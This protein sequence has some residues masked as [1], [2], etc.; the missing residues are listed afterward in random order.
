MFPTLLAA[1]EHPL[2]VDVDPL[3]VLVQLGF[4]LAALILLRAILFGPLL[5]LLEERDKAIHG[6]RQEAQ[7]LD[8]K[9]RDAAA[10]YEQEM[11]K[12]RT[13]AA[14]ETAKARAEA[15][16]LERQIV[17]RARADAAVT[18][19]EA[20]AR[21]GKEAAV[22]RQTLAAEVAAQAARVASQILGREVA[23]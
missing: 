22:V 1:S 15:E 8:E 23:A 6:A 20:R 17:E 18:L 12:I 14:A 7:A 19:S 10:R 16:A 21:L 2:P 9:A 4:V 5:R 3:T 11:R 13:G